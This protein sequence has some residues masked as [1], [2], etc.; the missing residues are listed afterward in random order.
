MPSKKHILECIPE[1]S[2]GVHA[3]DIFEKLGLTHYK[4]EDARNNIRREIRNAIDRGEVRTNKE[5]ELV[6]VSKNKET[7]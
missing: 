7:T 4:H 5:F 1:T 6:R 3:S 2:P